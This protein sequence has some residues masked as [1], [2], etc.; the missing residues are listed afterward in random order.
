[1]ADMSSDHLHPSGKGYEKMGK[2]WAEVIEEYLAENGGDPDA[3]ENPEI[4]HTDFEN[5]LSGW[6]SR[7]SASVDTTTSEAAEG[8][9]SASVTGRTADWNGIAY[10]LSSRKYPAGTHISVQAKVMQKTDSSVHFK[11]SMQYDNNGT[12]VYDTFIEKDV[13]PGE[14][15]TLSCADYIMKEGSSPILYVETDSDLCDFYLDEVL[16]MKTD[17]TVPTEP[18]TEPF[19]ETEPSSETDP[20]TE[21]E[22]SSEAEPSS[23]PEMRL[24]GDVNG[25]ATFELNDVILMQRWLLADSTVTLENVEA[26]DLNHDETLD[27]FDLTLMKRALLQHSSD[28]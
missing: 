3:P 27:V 5:G 10:S 23:E 12:A 24:M 8:S 4:L 17:G 13:A 2:F 7:G 15:M 20:V 6:S 25:D 11:V 16:V 1:M 18:E 14:W 19:S 21:T 22:P 26:A 9:L 28:S